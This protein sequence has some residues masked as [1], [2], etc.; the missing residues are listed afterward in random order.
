VVEHTGP[1]WGVAFSPDGGRLATAS[2]DSTARVWDATTVSKLLQVQHN[3]VNGVA[4]SPDGGR[5]ATASADST[6]RV[7]DATSTPT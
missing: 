6:A 3:W 5:L 2:A 4:F 1:V 7:W